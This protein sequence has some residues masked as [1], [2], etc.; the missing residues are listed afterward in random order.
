MIKCSQL[1]LASEM[2]AVMTSSSNWHWQDLLTD[3]LRLV[4]EKPLYR[5]EIS[6]GKFLPLFE[7]DDGCWTEMMMIRQTFNGSC[8]I[9]VN[10]TVFDL[11]YHW[12]IFKSESYF[13]FCSWHFKPMY[14][15]SSFFGDQLFWTPNFSNLQYL[16]VKAPLF[17]VDR[18]RAFGG[19][20]EA[21]F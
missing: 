11:S 9:P 17:F 7:V 10:G 1:L 2:L 15:V 4:M 12:W 8:R 19:V 14:S 20:C 16:R 3:I 21:D 6:L 18:T 5:S 13:T